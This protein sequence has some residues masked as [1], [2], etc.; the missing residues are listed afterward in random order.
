MAVEHDL[1][2]SGADLLVATLDDLAAG[3]AREIPQ[4]DS[5]AT[6]AP[7]LTKE[8]GL[9]DWSRSAR[10]IHNAIRG[11]H[12]WPHA[13]TFIGRERLILLR[14]SA[15]GSIGAVAEPGTILE[16]SGDGFVVATGSGLL[17]VHEVQIEGRRSMSTREFLA[18]HR[19]EGR[20]LG[21]AP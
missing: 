20:R 15:A 16:A 5:A 4:D 6:Y 14:S 1:A 3:T 12:P 10:A 17:A 19:I 21:A 11:L 2:R 7:R 13:Y 9:I 8:E 18:G